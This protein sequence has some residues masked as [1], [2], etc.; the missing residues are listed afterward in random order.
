[1]NALKY[2]HGKLK[3]AVPV[4]TGDRRIDAAVHGRQHPQ[5]R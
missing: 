4:F 2:W 5:R 3:R 1:M